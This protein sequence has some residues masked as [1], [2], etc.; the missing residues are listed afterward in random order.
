MPSCAVHVRV[1]TFAPTERLTEF[2]GL[3]L[4][5]A[6]GSSVV[7]STVI[8]VIL[9]ST[10]TVYEVIKE[11]K[12]LRSDLK[13][14]EKNYKNESSLE[15]KQCPQCAENVK[16]EAKICKHCRY[17]FPPPKIEEAILEHQIRNDAVH[18]FT[19]YKKPQNKST[20]FAKNVNYIIIAIIVILIV[21]ST[22]FYIDRYV[23]FWM[24]SGGNQQV[25]RYLI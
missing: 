22:I 6:A 18:Q 19:E 20:Y 9:F 3:L 12:G 17:E 1:T 23:V 11:L 13:I 15:R 10:S 21:L 7:P 4:T 2:P 16:N 5:V 24:N 14:V 8:E 25:S